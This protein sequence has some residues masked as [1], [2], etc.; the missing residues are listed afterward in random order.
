MASACLDC[1]TYHF[2]CTLLTYMSVNPIMLSDTLHRQTSRTMSATRSKDDHYPNLS[3]VDNSS[4][5]D[6]DDLSSIDD[7][8]SDS[9][10][11]QSQN[12]SDDQAGRSNSGT[13]RNMTQSDVLIAVIGVTGAGKTTFVSRVTGDTSL[14]IDDSVDS[15]T[16]D[17]VSVPCK[18]DGRTVTLIDTPGFDD[19]DRTEVDV[20]KLI[21]KHLMDKYMEGTTLNGIVFLQPINQSRVTR[22]ER[23]R[24]TLFKKLLG[25]SSFRRVVIGGTLWDKSNPQDAA[26]KIA[27]RSAN[28]DIWG[29]MVQGGAITVPYDNTRQG[30]LNIVRIL[31][32]FAAA[33][34]LIQKELA[35]G[36]KLDETAAGKEL[37]KQKGEEIAKLKEKMQDLQ[38]DKEATAAEVKALR[39]KIAQREQEITAAGQRLDRQKGEEIA[40]LRKVMQDLESERKSTAAEMRQLKEKIYQREE[41]IM[42]LK[43][44]C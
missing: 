19:H 39:D 27:Q 36:K 38:S 32:N 1:V 23:S 30:A 13:S 33:P 31:M 17:A 26:R 35:A 8:N 9:S 15:V 37:D 16:E 12:S 21:S 5:Y 10:V 11:D 43:R 25:E 24:T 2:H 22:T 34:I 3:S 41:E 44:G 40:K 28:R 29:D 20:L 42:D 7:S 18:I 4:S 14:R 6:S